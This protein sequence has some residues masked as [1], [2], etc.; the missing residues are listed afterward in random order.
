VENQPTYT[1]SA[2]IVGQLCN[3]ELAFRMR[4]SCTGL[5]L[6]VVGAAWIGRIKALREEGEERA[7]RSDGRKGGMGSWW[8]SVGFL[9]D[10][11]FRNISGTT[12]D[13]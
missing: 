8:G 3:K 6:I 10:Q 9:I 13:G 7:R 5:R 1:G 11:R 4:R 12:N 2:A